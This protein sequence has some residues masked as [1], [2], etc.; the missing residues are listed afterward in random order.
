MD[1][2]KHL[3][4]VKGEDKTQSIQECEYKDSKCMITYANNKTYSY[5]PRNVIWLKNPKLLN[6]ETTRVYIN[7]QPFSEV[8]KIVNFGE[9]VRIFFVNGYNIVYHRNEIIIKEKSFNNS[10]IKSSD[11]ISCYDYLKHLS[12]QIS[13]RDEDEKSF[14]RKQY[15]RINYVNP[16]SVLAKY[17][18]PIEL[19]KIKNN[20]LSIFPFGFNLSQKTATKKA[21]SEQI[22]IIEGPPGTGKTQTIL[23]IIANAI[24]NEKTVAVVSNNNSA[25]ANVLEKLQEQG[26]DLIAAFL[27]NNE[28]KQKFFS[29]QTHLY[30]DMKTWYLD[31]K[32]YKDLEQ[33]LL[34]SKI[35]LE[36]HLEIKNK[37][38]I[39]KQELSA[40]LVEQEYFNTYYDENNL[41]MEPYRSIFKHNSDTVLKL[42]LKFKQLIESDRA[43]SLSYKL[44]NLLL[45]GIVSFSFYNNSNEKI[46]ALFQKLYYENKAAELSAII[47]NLNGRLESFRFDNATEGYTNISMSLFKANLAKKYMKNKERKVFT[48]NCL[49]KEKDFKQFIKEYPVILST[50]HSLKSCISNN[51]L[52]DYVIIDEASQVDIVTGA[53][54]LSCAKNA[55]IVGDLK[56]LPMVVPKKEADLTNKIFNNYKLNK[57]YNYKNNSILSSISELYSSKV[58]KTILKEHYRCHPKIIGF[59]NQKFYNNE[60]IVLTEEQERHNPIV[61]YKTA[62]GNHARGTYNQRQI[63]VIQQEIIPKLKNHNTM[64]SVAIISPYRKQTNKLREK[65]NETNIEV[66]TVHKYQGRQRDIVILSTVVNEINEF[67]DDPNLINVAVSRAVDRLILIVSDNEKIDNS[68]IGDLVKYI[69]YN[70]FEI[71][72]S[73]IYSVFDLLYKKYT[74]QIYEQMKNRKKVSYFDSENL[75]NA[76]IEK[77][78]S[79]LQFANLNWVIHKPLRMLI[80]NPDKLNSEEYKFAMNILTHT[81]FVIFNKLDK[82]P[83]LVVEVDGYA[84]H[85]NNPRQLERDKMKDTILNKYGIPVLRVATNESGEEIKLRDKL[86]QVIN[87]N[88]SKEDRH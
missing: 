66:D 56:Q 53:L 34:I 88:L 33:K 2:E 12:T 4:I 7:K 87:S 23:N 48:K 63:D 83:V 65:E 38:A 30:P 9:Y 54:A 79:E 69:Q 42:W 72:D 70:N 51:Y 5:N 84:Y 59:C 39:Y 50:T 15:E 14:L 57:A 24:I 46:I 13:I 49:W 36:E 16:S 37:V 17:I 58:C 74:E 29:E 8:K 31:N 10:D 35:K 62:K 27:G 60:L 64:S 25:T 21:F 76:V 45:Y 82:M 68:N 43:I 73:K 26:V 1:V 52:F 41:R 80:R 81:D 78:L 22:S 77:V 3:I 40:L 32:T 67:V 11:V 55:V 20:I 18:N 61:V 19:P 71:I 28:N 6:P 44:K 47:N 75:I 85:A 86:N